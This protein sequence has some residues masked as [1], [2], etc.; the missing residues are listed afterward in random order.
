[1]TLSHLLNEFELNLDSVMVNNHFLIVILD[2][3]NAKSSL[4]DNN[5]I[6]TCEGSKT[7]G[8]TSQFELQKIIKEPTHTISGSW[9]YR[10][11]IFT[12]KLNL[13]MESAVHLKIHYP[14]LYKRGVW[15]YQK[16]NVDQI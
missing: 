3:Y 15:H 14:L 8:E 10:D 13:V 11:L 12:S 9:S 6:N 5:N 7:D 1:M 16:A 4:W 2:D